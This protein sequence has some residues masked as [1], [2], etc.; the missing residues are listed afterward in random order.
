MN[1][2]FAG[3]RL[4]GNFSA[5]SEGLDIQNVTLEISGTQKFSIADLVIDN[6]A[7]QR[8]RL[9]VGTQLTIPNIN[10]LDGGFQLNGITAALGLDFNPGE[11]PSFNIDLKIR[12]LQL[13]TLPFTSAVV[14]SDN[15]PI[16]LKL[17]KGVLSGT[18]P[19][20]QVTVFGQSARFS[21]VKFQHTIFAPPANFAA[22]LNSA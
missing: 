11:D 5:G 6:K 7:P 9:S 15:Q 13:P 8:L 12:S 21:G 16:N 14:I 18:V 3:G 4:L 19:N 20:F 2:Q 10:T 22:A 1:I 17:S